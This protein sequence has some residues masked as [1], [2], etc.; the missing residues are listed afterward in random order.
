VGLAVPWLHSRARLGPGTVEV[1]PVADG[2]MLAWE[3]R[4]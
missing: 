2:A 3:G 4:W 1:E